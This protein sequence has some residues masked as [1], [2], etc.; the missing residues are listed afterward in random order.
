MAAGAYRV[1]TLCAQ[2]TLDLLAKA[3]KLSFFVFDPNKDTCKS[4]RQR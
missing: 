2:L 3:D 4:L 1:V